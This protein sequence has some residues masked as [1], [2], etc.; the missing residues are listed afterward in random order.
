[1]RAKRMRKPEWSGVL[2]Y[3]DDFVESYAKYYLNDYRY[4]IKGR[5]NP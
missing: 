5:K 1:M 4:I 3:I 2:S